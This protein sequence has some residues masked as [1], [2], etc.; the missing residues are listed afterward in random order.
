VPRVQDFER[1]MGRSALPAP[2]SEWPN[3]DQVNVHTP[4]H[5]V[6]EPPGGP[7]RVLRRLALVALVIACAAAPALE[8]GGSDTPDLPL[9][10]AAEATGTLEAPGLERSSSRR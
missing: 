3:S 8:P 4:S 10:D 9:E 5:A 2:S 7:R 1:K 6:P